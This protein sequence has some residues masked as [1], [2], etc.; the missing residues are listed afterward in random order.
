MSTKQTKKVSRQTLKRMEEGCRMSFCASY[1]RDGIFKLLSS[2]GIEPKESIFPA[3]GYS[4]FA[5]LFRLAGRYD[6]PITIRFLAH[7]DYSKITAHYSRL[8]RGGFLNFMQTCTILLTAA[9]TVT[10][11]Q[12]YPHSNITPRTLSS[13]HQLPHTHTV[14]C[15]Y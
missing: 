15:I 4:L 1:F 12:L 13:V 6:S 5:S 14:T 3:H 11:T 2:P 8:Q 9:Y 10:H 7:I